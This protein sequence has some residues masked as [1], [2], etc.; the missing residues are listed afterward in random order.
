MTA[1]T[2]AAP[3]RQK[4][5]KKKAVTL[6]NAGEHEGAGAG[7]LLLFITHHVL[8]RHWLKALEKGSYNGLRAA[9]T[10]V[11]VLLLA[12]MPWPWRSRQPA[13]WS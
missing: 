3:A 5:V 4:T 1:G 2:S 10:A 8:N 12:D 13:R 11:D 6:R 9:Q 7:V